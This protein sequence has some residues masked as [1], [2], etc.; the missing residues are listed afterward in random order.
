MFRSKNKAM[1]H[2][3]VNLVL[4]IGATLKRSLDQLD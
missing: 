2:F 1:Q 4:K 3:Q